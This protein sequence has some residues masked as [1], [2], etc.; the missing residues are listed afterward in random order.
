[1]REKA[2]RRNVS[3]RELPS[4]FA[5]ARKGCAYVRKNDTMVNELYMRLCAGAREQT[6]IKKWIC[7]WETHIFQKTY[8]RRE[9]ASSVCIISQTHI[10]TEYKYT[11][12]DDE[13]APNRVFKDD[14]ERKSRGEARRIG[15]VGRNSPSRSLSFS[16][17]A[18]N[19]CEFANWDRVQCGSVNGVALRRNFAR[20]TAETIDTGMFVIYAYFLICLCDCVCLCVCTYSLAR[21]E[22]RR[23]TP[24]KTHLF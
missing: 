23:T 20:D 16:L 22:N 13:P 4:S 7:V 19:G 3:T 21:S 11:S 8:A 6:E 18:K 10:N 15:R 17:A 9:Q 2:S 24:T 5:H 1:M 12:T 14:N